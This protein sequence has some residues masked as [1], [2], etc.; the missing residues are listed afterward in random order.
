[1]TVRVRKNLG[2][3]VGGLLVAAGATLALAG[4]GSDDSSS[5]DASGSDTSGAVSTT[6]AKDGLD[7]AKK[8]VLP[9]DQFPAGYVV[10]EIP[11]GQLEAT[12]DQLLDA[13]KGV[14]V[15]PASCAQLTLLPDSIDVSSIG[16]A[17][18]MKGSASLSTSV[19]PAQVSMADQRKSVSGK[20]ANLKMKFTE[21]Q[22]AGTT[23]TVDQKVL[24]A[25][26]TKA[27]QTMVVEQKTTMNVSGT[28]VNSL[29]RMGYAEVNGYQVS[30]QYMAAPGSTIDSA[31]FDKTFI[32][33]VNRAVEGTD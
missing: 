11:A 18:A 2:R 25:P 33:A 4:C 23:A 30:V 1:M 19:A 16:L 12:T 31:A 29:A 10:Q 21:G 8:L 3:R 27:D 26:K 17:V 22:T 7:D 15:T 6:A 5:A 9:A 24:K 14:E 13:M 20:C 32:A 28:T